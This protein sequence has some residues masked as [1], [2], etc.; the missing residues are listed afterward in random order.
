M[1]VTEKC[2]VYSFGVVAL[3]V[4]IGKH[5]GELLSSHQN[6]KLS[7]VL[8]PR[9]SPPVDPKVVQDIVLVSAIAFACL[10]SKP[11]SRPTMALVS[12]E[13]A[14]CKKPMRKPLQKFPFGNLETKNCIWL[15]IIYDFILFKLL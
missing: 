2:D 11:N 13:L 9:L 14:A 10:R 5:P 4:L 8:D 6:I 7:D 3:E 1:V 15:L 12:K